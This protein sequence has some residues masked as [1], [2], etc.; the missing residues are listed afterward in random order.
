MR[1]GFKTAFR[2]AAPALVPLVGLFA[3]VACA[4]GGSVTDSSEGDRI[5][6]LATTSIIGD[7]VSSMVGDSAA[8]EVLL[9]LGVD[10]HDFEPSPQQVAS[11]ND[12]ELVVTNGLGL[13]EGLADVIEAAAAEGTPVL[14]LAEGVD[15]LA[16][17]ADDSSTGGDPHFWHDPDRMATA[18]DQIVGEL[19]VLDDT[20]DWDGQAA[21][22]RAQVIA[23]G[24]EA[25]EILSIVPAERRTLVTSH[26]S[27]DYFAD[28]FGFKV[29]ATVI[30]GGDTLGEPSGREIAELVDTIDETGVPAIFTDSASPTTLADTVAAEA[31]REVAVVDIFTDS[32]GEPGSGAETYLEMVLTNA[33]LVAEALAA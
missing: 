3:L 24:D 20:V 1:I 14:R 21:D 27:L 32:L 26:D 6:I 31:G 18:I 25:D 23:A 8:V 16:A 19:A 4:T 29:A 12:A 33:R 30:P 17:S 13:E 7:V 9:P 11:I 2:V 28:R 15:P 22:Y 10:P 5:E